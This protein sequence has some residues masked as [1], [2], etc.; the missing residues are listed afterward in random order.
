MNMNDVHLTITEIKLITSNHFANAKPT[1]RTNS[2]YDA[3][4]TPNLIQTKQVQ[5]QRE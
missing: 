1:H 3:F 4:T 2:E 5:K